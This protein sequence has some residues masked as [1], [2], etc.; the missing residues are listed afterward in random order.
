MNATCPTSGPI[1]MRPRSVLLN[2]STAAPSAAASPDRRIEV[3]R[4]RVLVGVGQA[5]IHV[6]GQMR[7][8]EPQ[9]RDH[10]VERAEDQHL[11]Q[12]P[13]VERVAMG[14]LMLQRRMQRDAQRAE[15]DRGDGGTTVEAGTAPQ[16][17]PRSSAKSAAA[18]AIRPAFRPFPF[19]WPDGAPNA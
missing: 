2:V 17:M 19:R 14:D 6:M 13:F 11:A 9:I 16:A 15:H 5:R 12:A 4:L 8:A 7:V 10:E 3:V 18:S 1:A